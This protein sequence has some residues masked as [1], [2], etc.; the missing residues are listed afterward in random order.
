MKDGLLFRKQKTPCD[1][2]V[3][4]TNLCYLQSFLGFTIVDLYRRHL[5]I[6]SGY[7]II[8][9]EVLLKLESVMRNAVT[10]RK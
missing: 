5:V 1:L 6:R 2:Q 9:H 4:H 7:I 8:L 10:N 3:V